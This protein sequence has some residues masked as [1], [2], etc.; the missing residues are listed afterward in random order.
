MRLSWRSDRKADAQLRFRAVCV[1]AVQMALACVLHATPTLAETRLHALLDVLQAYEQAGHRFVYSNDL[2]MRDLEVR[3]DLDTG[4]TIPGLKAALGDVGFFL[5]G[6]EDRNGATVWYIVPV[7]ESTQTSKPVSGRGVDARTGQPLSGVRVE[8]GSQVAYTDTEGRFELANGNA[9]AI[10]VSRQGYEAVELTP[11]ERLDALLEISLE[12]EDRLEEVV[13]VSSR[14]ALER[15]NGSSVH[16][17]TSQ[18]FEKTPEFGDDALRVACR[19][20]HWC[21]LTM[22]NCWSH[23]ISRI[24][25]VF[26]PDSIPVSSSR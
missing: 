19:T 4:L 7:T 15:S 13:V 18:D 16:T 8:I 23:S 25:R 20:K 6:T 17:L 1:L 3:I 10:Q 9:P 12:A 5:D 24:F 14:Y 22:W 11:T 21:S 26:F 2:V